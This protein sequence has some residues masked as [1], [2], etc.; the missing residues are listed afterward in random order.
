MPNHRK[1][2]RTA[3]ASPVDA[4][5]VARPANRSHGWLLGGMT[6]ALVAR[7]L[8][9]SES[10]ATHGDG[11]PLVMLWLA[12][13]VIWLL[14][15]IGRKRFTICFGPV[16]V[17]VLV[18]VAWQCVA[19]LYAV[20]HGSPRPAFN[21][22]WESIGLGLVFFL[23]R[24]LLRDAGEVRA[25]AAAMIA[26]MAA[27]SVYGIYQ[28][29]IELPA[30]RS[31]YDANPDALLHEAGLNFPPGA[32]LRDLLENRLANREPLA[33]FALTNSLAAALAPWLVV[34]LGIVAATWQQRRRWI[35]W[36]ICIIPIACC[37]LLT[38]SRSGYAAVVVGAVWLAVRHWQSSRHESSRHESSRHTPCAVRPADPAA[39][40]L[41]SRWLLADGTRSVPATLAG[42]SV[43]VG[44]L[45]AAAMIAG[46]AKPGLAK[47]ATSLGYRVQYWQATLQMIAD[48]PWLGC[49]PGNFQDVYTQY[50]LPEASEEVAD[51]HDFLLEVWATSG[52]PALLALLAVL[53]LFVAGGTPHTCRERPPW[54]SVVA[55]NAVP[56]ER[57]D[58]QAGAPRS[59]QEMHAPRND[60]KSALSG[61]VG[62]FLLSIPVGQIGAAPPNSIAIVI[63]L[64]V[65]V[66][67]MLLLI[68]WVRE[69]TFPPALAALGVA[70]LLVDLL[71]TGG[72][73]IPAIAQSLWL[74]LALGLSGAWSHQV[75]R[76]VVFVLLAIGL[77]LLVACQQSSYAHVLPCESFQ[78]L[79]RREYL[80][81]HRQSAQE[82]ARRAIDADPLSSDAHAFLAEIYLDAWLAN[83]ESADYDAFETQDA[84][85]RQMAP[86]AAPSGGHR[87]IATDGPLRRLTPGAGIC[88]R[89][90]S[91]KQS[92]LPVE[93]LS[94]IPAAATIVP[95]WL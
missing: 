15:G 81:G 83:L 39:V 62:G 88:N 91:R 69:G 43:L 32:P 71:T 50:K 78:R 41:R 77:G 85:A 52:S 24:Q 60:W 76:A 40:S 4:G 2:P 37:L 73:G 35:A 72:I 86:A 79:A 28:Y 30:M 56:T 54:R 5:R 38:R 16:D 74:L 27:I 47:A 18:L 34:G 1:T 93:P 21:M 68:P 20:R 59:L 44:L 94:C 65:A 82:L 90:R 51:P 9:P 22:L 36:L 87:P 63:G 13:L 53:G 57:H 33:T 75:P 80:D 46:F 92:R 11:L 23:A 14:A 7:P 66:A 42:A 3:N 61:L 70:V 67:C 29:A 12:L 55:T 26:L 19:A 25:V 10:A 89:K 45:V 84:L 49:G 31:Q 64:P 58:P 6:A 8:F 48:R 95:P 17:A